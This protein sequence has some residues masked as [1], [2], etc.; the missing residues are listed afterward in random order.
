MS[1]T[2]TT[3]FVTKWDTALRLEAQQTQSRLMGTVFDRGTIE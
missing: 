1:T 3:Q 2:I